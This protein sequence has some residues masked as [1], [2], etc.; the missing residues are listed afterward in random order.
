MN[1]LLLAA[2]LAFGIAGAAGAEPVTYRMDP[3]HT[4]VA[5]NWHH[6][7]Y[8]NPVILFGNAEGTIVYDADNVGASSV[9]VTI[10]LSGMDSGVDAFDEHLRSADFF[11][12]AQY[13]TITFDSTRVEAAGEGKLK[14]TGDLTVHGITRPVV[15]DVDVNR[16]EAHPMSGRPAAGFD[17][18]T[19]IKRSDFGVGMYV[20]NVADEVELHITTEAMVPEAGQAGAAGA[21]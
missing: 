6:F 21:G 15:L 19:T 8:S 10:P 18:T 14:V 9:D 11:D 13:P 7:G 17:A 4:Q 16:I 12:A 20:P 3:N 2:A 1:R 5:V